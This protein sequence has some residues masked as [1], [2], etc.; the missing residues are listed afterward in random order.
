GAIRTSVA[1][2]T[3]TTRGSGAPRDRKY[4]PA[5]AATRTMPIV[6]MGVNRW[7]AMCLPPLDPSS[8]NHREHKI[9]NGQQPQATPVARDL[10]QAR[11]ELVDSDHAVDSEIRWKNVAGG[12]H[13]LRD[14]FARPGKTGKE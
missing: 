13:L 14:C 7:L 4:T 6:V 12:E 11:T 8:R 10:P 1:R 9:D 5:P 3:P 2:T